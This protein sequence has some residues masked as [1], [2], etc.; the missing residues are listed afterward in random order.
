LSLSAIARASKALAAKARDGRLRP[1]DYQGGTASIS[2]LGMFGIDEMIPV[3][4]PPQALILGVGAGIEQ[5]WK[6]GGELA[7]AT[8][9]AATA[10]FDHRAID[11]AVAAEFMAALRDL[12]EVPLQIVS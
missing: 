9:M 5:P 12:I 8:V 2:N 11:G 6:V 1:E 4:N 7:L 10:S 3:I